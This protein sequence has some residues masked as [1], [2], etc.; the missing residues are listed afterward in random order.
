MPVL[1]D[2]PNFKP[3]P[4]GAAGAE[5]LRPVGE[6]RVRTWPVSRRVNRTGNGD[7]DPTLIEVATRTRSSAA[8]LSA[9]PLRPNR[10]EQRGQ[11]STALCE[12]VFLQ[13]ILGTHVCLAIVK[14]N[15]PFVGAGGREFEPLKGL[16]RR[17]DRVD[18]QY[19]SYRYIVKDT[20]GDAVWIVVEP[21]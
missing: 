14:L 10:I 1:L 15:E 20:Q 19:G 8:S 13:L 9:P 6:N 11:P 16:V 12:L 2:K 21:A 18:R 17:H 7:D 5:L 4:S 3:W